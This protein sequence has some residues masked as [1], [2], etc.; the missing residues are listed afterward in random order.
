MKKF[1]L[2]AVAICALLS[3]NPQ[4]D[5]TIHIQYMPFQETEK[6][7]WGLIGTDGQVLL[8]DEYTTMSTVAM[9]NRY[10]AKNKEGLWELYSI[11]NQR[12]K[13]IGDEYT[14]VG[15][16]YADVAPV[17]EKGKC[18]EFIDM[19]GEVRFT[20]D[21]VNGKDVSTCT[22]FSEGVAVFRIGKYCGAINTQGEVIVDPRYI[23][24]LPAHEG[25]MLA[26]DKKYEKYALSGDLDN[27]KYTVLSTTGEEL[28]TISTRR[29]KIASRCFENGALVVTNK[30]G[31]GTVRT[32]LIDQKGDWIMKPTDKIKSIKSIQD[33]TFIY[34]DGD[35]YGLM[36]FDGNKIIRTKYANLIF[37]N[38]SGLL[39]AKEDKED[40]EYILMD[41]NE[42]KVGREQFANVLPFI[43]GK[44]IVQESSDNWILIDE[45]GVDQRLK[46]DIYSIS[47]SAF[48]D[49]VLVSEYV[50]Y[51]AFTN[52]LK[53]TAN[54][55]LD[56]NLNMD[57]Q[58]I[59]TAITNIEYDGELGGAGIQVSPQA[60]I[61]KN[62]VLGSF[63]VNGIK[64]SVSSNFDEPI[65]LATQAGPTFNTITPNQ[66]GLQIPAE[67]I[68]G[69]K[70]GMM[71]TNLI[72]IVK[73]F[74]NTVKENSNAVIVS[75]GEAAYFVANN[76]KGV[77]VVY[78]LLDVSK[79]DITP[80][81][82]VKDAS[83]S[84][85][86]RYEVEDV[87]DIDP[88]MFEIFEIGGAF[89]EEEPLETPSS[90]GTHLSV[91]SVENI[92]LPAPLKGSVEIVPEGNGTV[93]VDL[94]EDNYPTISLTFKLL[95]NVSTASL[96]SS[97]GQ[98]WLVGHAQDAQGRD[99][100][101]LNPKSITSRE[102]RSGDSDGHDFK[103]F[104][105]GDVN[106]TITLLFH[107]ENNI[108]LFEKDAAKIQEGKAKTIE[109]A[110]EFAKFKL[111]IS[112]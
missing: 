80:Y 42:Q 33:N 68:L 98:M 79:I 87:F 57:A 88:S 29:Y 81:L 59:A 49:E 22:N 63:V 40:S 1:S 16:F 84:P 9:R 69:G 108:E 23:E 45:K 13:Q 100:Y 2:F 67:G 11:E 76:G 47:A 64:L 37:A 85:L 111:T 102:W 48:G 17:V 20:L 110:K 93:Y 97:Y 5:N 53:L 66:I 3:C 90:L 96:A 10:F 89:I 106:E 27:V 65:A 51:S 74:G 55:L 28:G 7:G 18:I 12:T 83:S 50:D 78:G 75:L 36:D 26:L 105:E 32:G 6:S 44:A 82:N 38:A 109:A 15:V 4:M 103:N 107:G 72:N 21:R 70:S 56:L 92:L 39:F 60:F 31:N 43:N 24:I 101:D 62:H 41:I 86:R 99:I 104:L 14:Q 112:N 54:G 94:D 77:D 71:T 8:D 91:L 58:H 25:K 95:K 46:Q 34:N 30:S 61:G 19:D 73:G 35:G 52:A